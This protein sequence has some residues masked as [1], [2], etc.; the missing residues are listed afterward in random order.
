MNEKARAPQWGSNLTPLD[1]Q[2]SALTTRPNRLT[3]LHSFISAT[4]P[5]DLSV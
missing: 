1:C 2:L 4:N 5:S 3:A